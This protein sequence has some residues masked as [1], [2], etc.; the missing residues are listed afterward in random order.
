MMRKKKTAIPF[1]DLVSELDPTIEI[2]NQGEH[3]AVVSSTCYQMLSGK[4]K[5]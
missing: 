2:L 1:L 3:A 5:L 4:R